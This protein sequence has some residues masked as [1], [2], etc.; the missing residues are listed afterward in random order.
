MSFR[1]L[2]VPIC[3]WGKPGPVSLLASTSN[4]CEWPCLTS[5]P[6]HITYLRSFWASVPLGPFGPT[7]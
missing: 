3:P 2:S 4:C 5:I 6:S 7:G 1:D